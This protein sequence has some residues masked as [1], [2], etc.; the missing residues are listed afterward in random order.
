[1]VRESKKKKKMKEG[2]NADFWGPVT[3]D[4]II[5]FSYPLCSPFSLA[6][7]LP[8]G[9][10]IF[11]AAALPELEVRQDMMLMSQ[12]GPEWQGWRI[13]KPVNPKHPTTPTMGASFLGTAVGVNKYKTT[14]EGMTMLL[15]PE[16]RSQRG[17]ILYTETGHV[18]EPLDDHLTRWAIKGVF[19]VSKC[20]GQSLGVMFN[21]NKPYMTA[22]P[23]KNLLGDTFEVDVST[24]AMTHDTSNDSLTTIMTHDF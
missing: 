21:I 12:D 8:L 6:E 10:P 11:G 5:F 16:L 19:G 14:R 4:S 3:P 18:C 13:G 15:T 24:V 9:H 1:M 2:K 20:E 23:D 7:M 22:S 17:T